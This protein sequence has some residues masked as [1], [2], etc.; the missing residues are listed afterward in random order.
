MSTISKTT[1]ARLKREMELM[2]TSPS[3]GITWWG[4]DQDIQHFE[5][6]IGRQGGLGARGLW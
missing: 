6:G 5:A 4:D 1:L 2:H 3:E